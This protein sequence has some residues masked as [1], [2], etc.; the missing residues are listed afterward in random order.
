M[1]YLEALYVRQ[2]K[3]VG[4]SVESV[5]EGKKGKDEKAVSASRNGR[6]VRLEYT[7]R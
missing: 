5:V 2:K 1:Q 4:E 6:A 7:T 3:L